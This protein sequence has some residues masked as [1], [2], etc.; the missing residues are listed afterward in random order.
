MGKRKHPGGA[1]TPATAALDRAG[2][3]YTLHP[4]AH[5]ASADSYGE[6][7]AKALGLSPDEMFKT[8]LVK[9]DLD[10]VVAVTP[11]RSSLDLKAVARAVGAKRATMAEPDSAER[12]TGYV[13]G[14]IS[15]LG[16]R[17]ALR[18]VL[19]QSARQLRRVYVS[20]GKRGVSLGISP[21]DLVTATG[22]LLA[23]ISRS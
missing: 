20:A 22:A 21:D 8:L 19:D 18:T 16:Q 1:G 2:I 10:V 7:A 11:V 14:G 12:L 23:P 6:E 3:A 9:A 13:I 4:Y 15:P 5:D 17:T